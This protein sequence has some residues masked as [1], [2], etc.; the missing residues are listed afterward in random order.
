VPT[1]WIKS[2][3]PILSMN[4]VFSRVA[5]RIDAIGID[6]IEVCNR[7]VTNRVLPISM[8]ERNRSRYT[9]KSGR[10]ETGASRLTLHFVWTV[11]SALSTDVVSYHVVCAGGQLPIRT[12]SPCFRCNACVNR[13]ARSPERKITQALPKTDSAEPI[14][15]GN[16]RRRWK[17]TR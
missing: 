15:P 11:G 8:D 7:L 5:L 9:I 6:W 1:I 3:V 13:V 2:F 10:F 17:K 4:I 16:R 14:W 12:T